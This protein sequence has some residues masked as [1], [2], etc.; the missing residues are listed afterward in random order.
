MII[1]DSNNNDKKE[2]KKEG[3]RR[4]RKKFVRLSTALR[5]ISYYNLPA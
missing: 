2:K 4:T 5:V 1:L 3:M